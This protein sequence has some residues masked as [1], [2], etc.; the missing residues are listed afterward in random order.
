M[1]KV[2]EFYVAHAETE[3]KE[4]EIETLDT[5]GEAIEFYKSYTDGE[6]AILYVTY[7][8]KYD[9]ILEEK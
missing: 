6:R 5:I 8:G 4:M 3:D 2:D 1:E 9:I 7:N